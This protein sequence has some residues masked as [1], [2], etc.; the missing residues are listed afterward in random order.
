MQILPY[1]YIVSGAALWGLIGV[2]VRNLPG[3]GPMQI[4][5]C[6]AWITAFILALFLLATDRKLLKIRLRDCWCFVGTGI[7]SIVF[8]NYCYFTTIRLCSLSAA[9]ILLYTAPS[10]VTL[11]SLLLFHEKLTRRKLSALVLAFAGCAL[12][13]GVG[14][15][16]L[17]ISPIGILAGLGSGFGYALYSIFAKY[18]LERYHSITVTT[19]T[20]L[21]A[22]IGVLPFAGLGEFPRLLADSPGSVWYLLALGLFSS[23][24]PYLLYTRG[25]KQVPAGKA[26]IMASIEPVVATLAGIFLFHEP[27]T[28]AGLLGV[29][30]VFA[31]LIVLNLP[32]RYKLPSD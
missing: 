3:F 24:I 7:F 15:S 18:A 31:S 14:Q 30:A 28:S 20:F 16:S 2:F 27:A 4:V 17:Q 26:S 21:F 13:S 5:A 29:A 10:F 23:A 1:L 19:Y 11:L 25:L 9:A 32:N 6:R 22:C 8:F 12:V